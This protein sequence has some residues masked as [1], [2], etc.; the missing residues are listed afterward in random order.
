ML[1]LISTSVLSTLRPLGPDA[2]LG[3]EGAAELLAGW[4]DGGVLA[5]GSLLEVPAED[6][7][8]S[9]FCPITF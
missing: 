2:G 4:D 7:P 9:G 5:A 6:M 1:P 8:D 3:R